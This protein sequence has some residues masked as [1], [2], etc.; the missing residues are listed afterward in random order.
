MVATIGVAPNREYV[1]Q[2]TNY[3]KYGT[4]GTGDSYNFQIRLQET[5][6]N[7]VIVYGTVQNNAT[8]TTIQIGL[9]GEP[10]TPASNFKVLSSTT[11]WASPSIGALV[12]ESLT[13]SS[14]VYPTS[15]TTYTFSPPVAEAIPNPANLVSPANG[16][17]A[18]TSQT[19]NWMSGGGLPDSF[20]VY[21][22]T[23]P[24]PP[25]IQNQ[26][27]TTYAPTLAAGTTYYW[28]IVPHNVHGSAENCPIWNFSTLTAAQLFES[29]EATTFPP[30]GWGNPGA[31]TR[32][33]VTPYHG[34]AGAYKFTNTTTPFLLHTPR[35]NIDEQSSLSFWAR[36]AS[37]NADQ[38][39][40]IMY[41]ADATSW[42]PVGTP[43]ALTNG[44]N[45]TNYVA[46]LS[47]LAGNSYFIGFQVSTV[48]ATGSVY[49]D[50][51]IGP[52]ITPE[53]PGVANNVYPVNGGYSFTNGVLSWTA[54][55]GIVSSYD[56]YFGTTNP[57]AFVGNQ[58]ET[59]Y[60]PTLA[61][62]TTYF[63]Q[64]VP[65]NVHGSAEDCP[66]WSFSSPLI[67]Q[68]AE[69]FEATT[70]PPVGW[71]N[72]G[73]YTRSTTTPFHGTTGAYKSLSTTPAILSTPM[74]TITESSVLD[75][76]YRTAS[77]NGFGRLQI[78]YSPDR[79]TWTA[80]GE[81]IVF[82]TTTTWNRA[83]V[84]LGSL[85]GNN[86]YIAFEGYTTSST[87]TVYIDHVF[88]PDIT[89]VMPGPVT[90][91]A[92]A[93]AA[94][95]VSEYPSFTWTNATTGGVPNGYR[96]YC[97]TN[98]NP[99]TLIGTATGSP[100]T[101]TTPLNWNTTYYW[102]VVPFNEA[103]EAEGNAIRS[104]TVRPNPTISTFP[105]S[106]NFGT[107]GATFPP[108][109][110]SRLTGFIGDPLTTTTGGWN[111]GN[112]VNVAAT[113]VNLSARLNIWSTTIR[114]WLVTPPLAIPANDFELKFDLGLTTF[115]GTASPD[116]TLQLDDR[117]V[118]LISDNPAMQ[119]ATILRE[120]NNSGSPYVYNQISNTGQ[121]TGIELSGYTGTKY[122][123]FYG[124][125]TL[126]GGD[127][128]V[129]VDNVL[130]REI[131]EAP[132][133]SV[134][135][136]AWN[137][138]L[139]VINTTASKDFVIS[140]IGGGSL[141]ISSIG[142]SGD[143]FTLTSNPAPV[144]LGAGQSASFTVQYLPTAEGEHTG[145]IT[146]TDGR[147]V[148]T[149]SLEGACYDPTITTFPYNQDFEAWP[150]LGWDLTGGSHSFVQFTATNG[151]NWARANF[152]SQTGGSTD[153]MTTPPLNPT[154]ASQLK[155]TWSHL[156]SSTYPNDALTVKISSDM[157]NWVQLWHKAGTELNSAD[158][159]GNTAPG[160]GVQETILI[161]AAYI[162]SPFF[163]QFFGYSGF[164][165]DLFIDNV[166]I[167]GLPVGA[168]AHVTL[169]APVDG[170]S[171][172]NPANVILQWNPGSGGVPEYYQIFVA[173][174]PDLI[175]DQYFFE[176]NERLESFN[177]SA[178]A[179]ITLDYDQTW[180]W[181]VVPVNA[182]GSPDPEEPGFML[183]NFT[184]MGD[185]SITSFPYLQGFE[186]TTFPPVGWTVV[187]ND[188]SATQWVRDATQNH[189]PDGIASARH[190]FNG[191][192]DEDGWLITPPVVIPTATDNLF[193]S[194]WSYNNWP[195]YME[196]NGVWVSTGSSNPAD[197]HFV[198]IWSA[199][200]V[201]QVWS[202]ASVSLA[203]FA[204]QTI[205]IG[206]RYMGYDAD[207][208]FLD[209]IVLE[210]LTIDTIPPVINH[211]WLTNTTVTDINY[212]VYANVADDA[213]WNSGISLVEL[214]YSTDTV[215]YT[216][217]PM[218]LQ[219]DGTYMATIPAQQL[220]TEVNY[221]IHAVDA[222]SENNSAQTPTYTFYVE[223]PTWLYYDSGT[224]TDFLGHATASWGAG[225]MFVNP[226]GA[227]VPLKINQ[228]VGALYNPG[229]AILHIYSLVD[230]NLVPAMEQPMPVTFAAGQTWTSFDVDVTITSAAFMVSFEEVNFPNYLALDATSPYTN[231]NYFFFGGSI[232]TLAAA[233][234]SGTWMISVNVETG[235]TLGLETPL[236]NIAT[237]PAGPQLSWNAIDGASA[238]IIQGAEDPNTTTWNT[239]ATV[240][241]TT[242][243]HEA[244]ANMHFFRV[245]ATTDLP[246]AAISTSQTLDISPL[247]PHTNIQQAP[248][249]IIRNRK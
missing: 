42:T 81:P 174:D 168:P 177:L 19:L 155:F 241:G 216:T 37:T 245:M 203:A 10:V 154:E 52:E 207:D 106:E 191:S 39:I 229:T 158:G 46:D 198:E 170:A 185:V 173:D 5:T 225:T 23:S 85:A 239:L 213:T 114:H 69:G 100:Y 44:T 113:P 53:A 63:W 220:N 139:R 205:H 45:W 148:T 109:N 25:F 126:A 145:T 94:I 91:S 140:N 171:D 26:T 50:Y 6:N 156:Y 71:A 121:N 137:Y 169:V 233:G 119:N 95:N 15:G 104:F 236:V 86:Y 184:T 211:A 124:E 141:D 167:E 65:R 217:V 204:G 122:I 224:A 30:P 201:T 40:T 29:F 227:G 66:I 200:S 88:G 143:F 4:T 226:K 150:P 129:F 48:G 2:W 132:V 24:T 14:T 195:T 208:W 16:G 248:K 67:G 22:G 13:L 32:S 21:F 176:T 74:L 182:D 209:D 151:N 51:V 234:G 80:V 125:S 134:T 90:L 84:S 9:R 221:Y 180:Y 192:N 240:S 61:A 57:P 1:V 164:G 243:T 152:W 181:A 27:G 249:T 199:D 244:A 87:A 186:S 12:T 160:T 178:Q 142:I 11:N 212:A 31:F 59:T 128:Y 144:V 194:F 197:G 175:F 8:A 146:I 72:P 7:V 172:V 153:I 43:F 58:T 93:N 33:T 75:F 123:A 228:V 68:L 105:Y 115:S 193:L 41:S 111:A 187:N 116:P 47:T 110:W 196:Y 70:F 62:S 135:P 131:P 183:W 89:P 223:D 165:P 166:I 97:D 49:I 79:V 189:T 112:W 117:F 54:G 118:V 120:W 64:V 55:T 136:T 56:V 35:L 138:G 238:Y 99:T 20:D 107:T 179:G 159:A 102:K 235:E 190:T 247:A 218:L 206:F 215:N 83:L 163:V 36:T 202:Q 78:K 237:S 98:P 157:E 246:R 188:G 219:R 242:Y 17:W 18:E 38:R 34:T 161:P 103:G 133:F 28:Q 230:G 147:A 82:P 96:V 73:T 231:M 222:S 108:L 92:P 162:G 210:E 149:V 101:A 127:N 60:T 76:Y 130:V 214:S 3:K 232:Y 77:T